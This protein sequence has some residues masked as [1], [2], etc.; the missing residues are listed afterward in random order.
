MLRTISVNASLLPKS[1]PS[2]CVASVVHER[3]TNAT[4]VTKKLV[5]F[6]IVKCYFRL[7]LLFYLSLNNCYL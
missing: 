6:L 7:K 4:I 1:T 2:S 3:A 5:K